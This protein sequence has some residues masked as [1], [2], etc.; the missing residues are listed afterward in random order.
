MY[1]HFSDKF[2]AHENTPSRE[3]HFKLHFEKHNAATAIRTFAIK[4]FDFE[5]AAGA[6]RS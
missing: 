3:K 2:I 6:A 4:R 5:V 1:Y